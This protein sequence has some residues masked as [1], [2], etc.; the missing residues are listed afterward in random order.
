MDMRVLIHGAV[1]VRV[2]GSV[3]VN[4]GVRMGPAE[5]VNQ[6]ED[7]VDHT[8]NQKH[9]RRQGAARLLDPFEGESVA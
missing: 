1:L 5:E 4:M 2:N 3:G 7:H 9:P 8:E 6:T